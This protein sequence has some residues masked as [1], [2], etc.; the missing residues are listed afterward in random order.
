MSDFIIRIVYDNHC[1][2]P[3]F[4][5]GFGFSALIFNNI[6]KSYFLF[7][8][9]GNGDVLIHNIKKFGINIEE[10]KNV[11]ISHNHHDHA[12]GLQKIYELNPIIKIHIPKTKVKSFVNFFPKANIHGISE[13]TEI[14]KSMYSSGELGINFKEQCLYLQLN[15]GEIIILVGCAHPGLERYIIKGREIG[16][17]KAVIGGF[18]GFNKFSFLKGIDFIGACHCTAHIDTIA[19][20]FPKQFKRI[21]VG[22]VFSF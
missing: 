13:F 16:P 7:D 4:L 3:G 2:E 17:I 8:T 11:V 19:I 20:N 15:S 5:T 14:A 1:Y 9:G 18:H 22:S 21:C 6:I 12:G 10:I